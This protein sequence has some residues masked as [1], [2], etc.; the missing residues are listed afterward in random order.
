MRIATWSF[1]AGA[2][3]FALLTASKAAAADPGEIPLTVAVGA[4]A[5]VGP[6]PV[7]QVICDDGG[8]VE[9][10]DTDQGPAM[11]GLRPGKTVCSLID[12]MS[13]RRVYRVTVA[14][15]PPASGPPAKV[16]GP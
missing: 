5:P 9:I 10:V 15:P 1:A 2:L 8:I 3:A 16:P 6:G 7:R 4:L 13:V 14:S 11:R 12:A